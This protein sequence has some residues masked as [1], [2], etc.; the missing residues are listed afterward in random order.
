MSYGLYLDDISMQV[1]HVV[2]IG[3]TT[4]SVLLLFIILHLVG[5]DVFISY[6]F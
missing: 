3:L 5:V 2:C 4:Y 1:P 6:V